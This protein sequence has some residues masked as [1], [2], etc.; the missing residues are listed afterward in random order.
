MRK[1]L[2]KRKTSRDAPPKAI[3]LIG[4][5]AY[6]VW[7]AWAYLL[8]S[9]D[10]AEPE[11]RLFFIA[12]F[13]A[14]IFFTVLFLFY[15]VGK[16]ISGKAAPLVFYPSAR[17][18]LFVSAFFLIAALMQLWGILNWVTGTTLALIMLLT[19]IWKSRSS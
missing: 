5:L 6:G 19:E 2:R 16:I 12:A 11:N 15:Q 9:R 4:L 18:A 13:S 14:A 8:F 3:Y 1:V 10:P 17:R 7:G